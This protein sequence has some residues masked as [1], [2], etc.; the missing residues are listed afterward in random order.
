M[1]VTV[2]KKIDS[3]VK[4]LLENG[5]K[6]NHRSFVVV[7]G[8]RAR[9][10]IVNIHYLLSKASVKA[11]PT[12]LW[13]Y[14]NELDFSANKKKRIKKMKKQ[15]QQGLLEANKSDPFDLFINSTTIR[16]TYYSESHKILGNTFGM[17]VLQDFE[18]ITPNV[19]ARTI[20]TVE[21]GGCVLLLLKSMTSLRQLYTM[22]MDVHARLRTATQTEITGRFVERFILSLGSCP[23]CLVCDEELNILPISS[24]IRTIQP[25]PPAQDAR[26]P[27]QRELDQLKA[28]MADTEM[29]G[30]LVKKARTLDQA[31]ALLVFVEAIT[32]KTLRTTVALTA[33]RGRGKSAA[34][35]LAVACAIGMGYS[36][37][38]VS[39]PHPENLKTFFEFL[40]QGF[41]AL[42]YKEHQDYDLLTSTNP[43]YGV[44]S[45]VRV[46]VFHSHR[47]TVQYIHPSE[48]A[49]SLGHAELLVIDEAA[50][51]PLP[52]VRS[53]FGP[54][55]LFLAST[56]NGY[57]GTG[58]ALSLKL[59]KGLRDSAAAGGV[60]VLKEISLEEPI[61]YAEGDEVELWLNKLLCLDST[62]VPPTAGPGMCPHPSTANLFY[63]NKDALFSFHKASELF[64]QRLVS[65]FVSSHYKNSPNDLL[66]MSDAPAHHLFVLLGPINPNQASELPEILCAVQVCI[67]G[68][69]W[70]KSMIEGLEATGKTDSGDLIPWIISQ[71]YQDPKFGQLNGARVVRIATHPNYQAMGYGTRSL[72]LLKEFYSGKL[73]DP[74]AYAAAC[75]AAA[76]EEAEKQVPAA[77]LLQEVIRP[78]RL[79]QS[80]LSSL[81]ERRAEVLDYIG[82]SFGVTDQL[83][84]FWHRAGFNPL[85]V[86][87]TTNET[88]G[89]HTC[90]M[91]NAIGSGDW[92]KALGNDFRH[93]FAQLL[94]YDLRSISSDLAMR[95]LSYDPNA[96]STKKGDAA[97]EEVVSRVFSV[98]D[99]QRLEAY[100]KAFLDYHVVLDMV[101]NTALL[102]VEGAFGAR[103]PLNWLQAQIVVAM[104]LQKKNVDTVAKE[105]QLPVNQVL[106]FFN[107]AMRKV[108]KVFR[109]MDESKVRADIGG[110]RDKESKVQSREH[111]RKNDNLE[112][113]E[114][115]EAARQSGKRFD[116]IGDDY[117]LPEENDPAWGA[118]I[119]STGGRVPTEI[120]VK[121]QKREKRERQ[122]KPSK[123]QQQQQQQQQQKEKRKKHRN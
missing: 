53:M 80:L 15:A 43:A 93:R 117:A 47:Q 54:H 86:R 98:Y 102:L 55:L 35:G 42:A 16:Y 51:I 1:S 18:S 87:L 101:P 105:M 69:L 22:V 3:R 30:A 29:I 85:Y 41:D 79:K 50:A 81:G 110:G 70:G 39:S 4:T 19:L 33:A 108:A 12:V 78:R 73:D 97:L 59:I 115:A 64:L 75:A 38:F 116:A 114:D 28:S 8:D 123:Q 26:S 45:I 77:G 66:L 24:H 122:H 52:L 96:L 88:T 9:E 120:I 17:C 49:S 106:A 23:S 48:A 83:Y 92:L 84:R 60:R 44:G 5:V 10:Q 103:L 121:G 109:A 99:R 112:E 107:K 20:E 37:V 68:G 71:Q 7:V 89:E 57:E 90:I 82:V 119:E 76:E 94:G 34:L 61:R 13:C 72:E 63:V 27:K 21:G 56:V 58:R 104:G 91:V 2:R 32:E 95:L 25:L 6:S 118:A 46:N 74:V 111:D 36:N 14:K 11:R 113:D 31:R 65:L 67:E 100:S 40:F 62:Q